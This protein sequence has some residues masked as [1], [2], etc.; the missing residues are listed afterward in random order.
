MAYNT[1]LRLIDAKMEQPSGSTLTL[2]GNTVFD[3]G[4]DGIPKYSTHPDFTGS[5]SVY[6]DNQVLV[7]KEYVDSKVG[8][9]FQELI[10]DDHILVVLNDPNATFGKYKNNDTIPASGKTPSWVILDAVTEALDPT[11]SLSSTATDVAYGESAKTVTVNYS[12]DIKTP[13]AS[14][15]EFQLEWRRAGAAP[16]GTN[17]NWVDLIPTTS[18]PAGS[19][20]THN[21]DD[22]A[23]RFNTNSIEY[24][25]RVRDSAGGENITT[26]TR[27]MESA[28]TATGSITVTSTITTSTTTNREKADTGSTITSSVTALRTLN[29]IVS[30]QVQRNLNGGGYANL[31]SLVNITP[32]TSTSITPVNDFVAET[33]NNVRYKVIY[34]FEDGGTYER[35][36]NL[37]TFIFP[38]FWGYASTQPTAGDAL[39]ADG[40][41]TK[42]L[43]GS[44]G[45]LT[46]DFGSSGTV[47]MWFATP[48]TSTTKVHWVE[49]GNSV[50]TGPIGNTQL[51]ESPTTVEVDSPDALWSNEDYKFYIGGYSG[52]RLEYN[53]L[54]TAP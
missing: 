29:K 19:P 14:L 20:F 51:F 22:S 23:D 16:A 18:S 1:K 15:D 43:S 46:I 45:D 31:G 7:D 3:V 12:Y 28:A 5:T 11:I 34:N 40:N 36:S 50:N 8:G 21:I 27:A 6:N 47:Y 9:E 48:S 25:L 17:N 24:R 39:L 44:N 49:N 42:V 37:I 30:Y 32:T 41:T 13:N 10:F 52:N 53:L 33:A 54:N 26:H 38:Y 2:S 4:S 35:Q